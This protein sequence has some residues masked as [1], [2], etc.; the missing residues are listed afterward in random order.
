[1]IVSPQVK[2]GFVEYT[3]LVQSMSRWAA[4]PFALMATLHSGQPSR[5][6]I[7]GTLLIAVSGANANEMN[8]KNEVS[9][10]LSRT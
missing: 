3:I 1:M 6:F 8:S 4:V 5:P 10:V 2:A 9:L 7:L